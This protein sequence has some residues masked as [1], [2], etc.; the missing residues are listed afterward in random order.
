MVIILQDH[1]KAELVYF[2]FNLALHDSEAVSQKCC[3]KR[4]R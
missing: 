2:G 1:F 3:K 4:W